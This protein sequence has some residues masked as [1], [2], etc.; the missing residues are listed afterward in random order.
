IHLAAADENRAIAMKFTPGQQ[1]GATIFQEVLDAASEHFR[2]KRAL[3]DRAFDSNHIR[4][5]L[6]E[7][8]IEAVIPP[9]STRT[10]RWLLREVVAPALDGR[11][12]RPEVLALLMRGKT[13]I[14]AYVQPVMSYFE[15]P[16]LV[17]GYVERL[18]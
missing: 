11:A 15:R 4:S 8:G 12:D 13:E 6:S 2:A 3:A 17:E 10:T 7:R 18:M 1:G 5:L 16:D 9:S 14:G